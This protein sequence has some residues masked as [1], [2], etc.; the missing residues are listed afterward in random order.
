MI[1]DTSAVVAILRREEDAE[2][3]L[4]ALAAAHE[5]GERLAMSAATLFEL[6]LVI[7]RLKDPQLSV[8]TDAFMA[9]L[10]L[11]VIDVT[12]QTAAEARSANLRFGKGFHPAKLNFGD[13][14]VYALAKQTGEPL[15]FKGD[16][17]AQTD[18]VSA[19]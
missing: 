4:A 17:F 6:T 5:R 18:I 11:E 15:L 9:I 1:V 16:D 12:A 14:L 3:Y 10:G 8:E 7:D 13:C 2:R 19:V